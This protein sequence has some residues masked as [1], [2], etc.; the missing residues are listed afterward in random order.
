MSDEYILGTDEE[1]LARLRFQHEAWLEE[2]LPLFHRVGL[3]AGQTVL[4]LGCGPGYTTLELATRVGP[5]G[6]VIANDVSPP[7]L[8]H[9]AA[10][11]D[12]LRIEH[13]EIRPG[14][15]EELRLEPESIDAAYTRWLLCW[16]PDPGA[17]VERVAR[18]LKPRAAFVLQEY[19]NWGTMKLIPR[20]PVHDTVV[21]ACLASWPA[22]GATIDIVEHLPDLG[23]AHG[24]ELELLEPVARIG[25]AGS[26]VW[27]W[28]GG[29]YG[30][31]LPRLVE[32]GLLDEGTRTSFM[33]AWERISRERSH[34]ICAPTVA[35]VILRKPD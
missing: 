6:R 8:A 26:M 22:G 4:D 19:L 35:N 29:F 20:L 11:V 9:L 27:N 14:P 34:H 33:E 31:Y 3:T 23:R 7:F 25:A 12:R 30:S 15:V 21:D 2:A 24:L 1:E 32:R 13:V 28:L 10:E 16:L 18:A 17:V 5:S